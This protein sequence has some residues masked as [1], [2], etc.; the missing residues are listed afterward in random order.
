MKSSKK[1]DLDRKNVKENSLSKELR[2]ILSQL[3]QNEYIFQ[4]GDSVTTKLIMVCGRN[5]KENLSKKDK[6]EISRSLANKR[7][8]DLANSYLDNLRQEARIVFK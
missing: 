5:E 2:S 6:S 1:A 3:D 4:D 7:L 8:L